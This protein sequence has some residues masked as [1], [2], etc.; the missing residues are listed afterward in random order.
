MKYL[1][2]IIL[3]SVG[4]IALCQQETQYEDLPEIT[5]PLDTDGYTVFKNGTGYKITYA[6]LVS[7]LNDAIDAKIALDETFRL[8]TI[9]QETSIENNDTLSVKV[10]GVEKKI[11][12]G[13]LFSTIIA[14]VSA[15]QSDVVALQ[16]SVTILRNDLTAEQNKTD[17][18]SVRYQ[19]S[20]E[21]V[22]AYTPTEVGQVIAVIDVLQT[23][24]LTPPTLVSGEVGNIEDSVIVLTMSE[25]ILADSIWEY[26]GGAG[27]NWGGITA[28]YNF[29]ET[30]GLAL[31]RIGSDDGV[32]STPSTM[33]GD[34]TGIASFAYYFDGDD[35]VDL[36]TGINYGSNDLSGSV[37]VKPHDL[38]S[39]FRIYSGTGGFFIGY[40]SSSD[41]LWAG[42]SSDVLSSVTTITLT[43]GAWNHVCWSYDGSDV[44]FWIN[45]SSTESESL[46]TTFSNVTDHIGTSGTSNYYT[47]LMDDLFL[48]DGLEMVQSR[49]DSLYNSG[50]GRRYNDAGGS[51][52]INSDTISEAFTL[53]V[54]PLGPPDPVVDSVRALGPTVYLYLD[55]KV[56]Y[57]DIVRLSYAAPSGAGLNRGM[58]DS[59]DNYTLDWSIETMI[60]NVD[61]STAENNTFIVR[62]YDYEGETF[63]TWTNAEAE[64]YYGTVK[65]NNSYGNTFID[66]ATI[67]DVQSNVL[68]IA[69]VETYH[70]SEVWVY[71][72]T[73]MNTACLSYYV[74]LGENFNSLNDGKV[75]GFRTMKGVTKGNLVPS[76]DGFLSK[77]QMKGPGAMDTYHK[78]Y[79]QNDFWSP[80]SYGFGG[81][82]HGTDYKTSFYTFGSWHKVDMYLDMN[83]YTG[84]V[85]D[86]NGIFEVA[87]NDSLVFQETGITFHVI[88]AD[89]NRIQ[90][91]NISSFWGGNES[92]NTPT[93]THYTYFDDFKVYV[94]LNDLK[95]GTNELHTEMWDSPNPAVTND[96]Y[97][98]DTITS[99]T[100]DVT[101][102][103]D[104][105][106]ENFR[107]LIDA[108][109]GNK[110][111]LDWDSGVVPSGCWVITYDG[112]EPGDHIIERYTGE[113]GTGNLPVATSSVSTGQYMYIYFTSDSDGGTS[114]SGDITFSAQ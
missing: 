98:D 91:I 24:D 9:N 47:G 10:D 36:G 33:Q 85:S 76:T 38:G 72:D 5:T 81:Q 96:L 95:F 28:A 103:N 114:F 75:S 90:V 53:S 55:K 80:W 84:G 40:N 32:A 99:D 109:S 100:E 86:E 78:D 7:L 92:T 62:E 18:D 15:L 43:L 69:Q 57:G 94:P 44:T 107:W 70:G 110:V 73:S 13:D 19:S 20:I 6:V 65:N 63:G 50:D 71:I 14:T 26:S 88:E 104:T 87:L 68:R 35:Q 37:W 79:T 113:I 23:V 17:F 46:S 61:T 64:T 56:N 16:D 108:G 1:F 8:D 25:Y 83:T 93:S 82:G 21:K 74:K 106:H 29:D 89:T 60:N 54:L 31:D 4:C 97:A 52:L 3:V 59:A 101:Y 39:D 49:V 111:T 102:S 66:T 27:G 11:T 51:I 48:W 42:R 30:S 2:I 67:N 77:L 112:K 41:G 12:I 34:S 22:Y 105:G 45:A 58:R